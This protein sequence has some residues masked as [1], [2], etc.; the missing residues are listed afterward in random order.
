MNNMLSSNSVLVFTNR[1]WKW[2]S[3]WQRHT[4]L[5][6][7]LNQWNISGIA[8]SQKLGMKHHY[9]KKYVVTTNIDHETEHNTVRAVTDDYRHLSTRALEALL[10]IPWTIIH[11]ILSEKLE[12]V[13]M[14]STW[15]PHMLTSDWM[16]IC[17]ESASKFPGLIAEDSTYLNRVVTCD[18]T[19]E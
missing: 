9:M 14:A 12:M 13:H 8:L 10:H 7:W 16:W 1:W 15:L 17:I 5:S 3:C 2:L 19:W 6:V 18:E 4:A 11:H